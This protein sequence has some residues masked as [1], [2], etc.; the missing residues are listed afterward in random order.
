MS[1][2]FRTILIF[3]VILL[4]SGCGIPDNLKSRVSML[5]GDFKKTESRFL[6]EVSTY[7]RFKNSS[8]YEEFKKYAQKENWQKNIDNVKKT[9]A[10]AK[11][12]NTKIKKIL[13]DDREKDQANLMLHM[14]N[15]KGHIDKIKVEYPKTNKRIT[16]IKDTKDNSDSLL[17]KANISYENSQQR[18]VKLKDT[19][20]Q[21]AI[22]FPKKTADINK[23]AK[24]LEDIMGLNKNYILSIEQEF[25]KESSKRDYAQFGDSYVGLTQN[26]ILL[27]TSDEKM[28]KQFSQLYQSYTKILTDMRSDLFVQVARSTWD[29]YAEYGSDHPY[30]YRPSKVT[31]K[32][33]NYFDAL[34]LENIATYGA[35]WSSGFKSNIEKN[36]WDALKINHSIGRDNRGVWWVLKMNARYY[37]KYVLINGENR[38]ES[39]WVEVKAT[40]FY[41]N[42]ANLGMEILSKPYGFYE[43]E[44]INEASPAGMSLVGNS[45]YGEWRDKNSQTRSS[46]GSVGLLWFFFP[47]YGFYS[48]YGSPYYRYNDYRRYSDYRTRRQPYYGSNHQYGTWGSSTYSNNRYARSSYAQSHSAGVRAAKS[49][50][51]AQQYKKSTSSIKRAGSST[52]GRGPSGGGK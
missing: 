1:N 7:K 13:D 32:V 33:Y 35:G 43:E 12:I 31:S 18:Y 11:Q 22:D 28:R 44:K 30:T 40:Y 50:K 3:G 16:F 45:K 9:V 4:I 39:D 6:K 48:S 20:T 17:E 19:L 42:Q 36:M 5:Q 51:G 15:F 41:K 10:N 23:K 29:G 47:R 27:K 25:K 49:G 46:I 2:I 14:I 37:H 52:R 26:A 38:Q 34:T 8:E 24:T 21:V